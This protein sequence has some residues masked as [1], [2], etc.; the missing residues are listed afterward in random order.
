[1]LC[2]PKGGAQYVSEKSDVCVCVCVC[3]NNMFN[4]VL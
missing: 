4:N 3:V 1:M 2:V